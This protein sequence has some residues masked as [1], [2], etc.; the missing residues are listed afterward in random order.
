MLTILIADDHVMFVE[1]LSAFFADMTT[2]EVVGRCY[3][4]CKVLDFL[5]NKQPD[6]ILLDISLPEINGLDLCKIIRQTYPEIKVLILS[7]HNESS[8]ITQA[9]KNGANGY[10]LKSV[11]GQQMKQGIG[12]VMRGEV[13]YSAEVKDIILQNLTHQRKVSQYSIVPKLSRREKEILRLIM[14]EF[15]T[16][17][18]AD[19][20]F[21]S[22]K[23]IEA[24]RSHLLSKTGVRNIAGLVK[25]A[26]ELKLLD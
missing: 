24:A 1:G 20:L 4:G 13:Y 7:M 12:A 17:E 2:I 22:A 11:D 19:K 26:L 9:M 21:L 15:T 23:T 18:I 6:L 8:I 10:L 16:Q 25:A 5:K 3:S 14:D